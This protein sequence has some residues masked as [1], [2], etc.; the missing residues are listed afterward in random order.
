MTCDLPEEVFFILNILYTHRCYKSSAGYHSE[1]LY[2]LFIRKE[3]NSEFK[4]I[5]KVLL[6]QGYISII[7]KDEVKYYIIDKNRVARL[8]I[9]HGYD[10]NTRGRLHR[11]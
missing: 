6:N 5:I 2:K 3:F 10:V 1:K 7:K 4:K 8:L 11:L 9:Q